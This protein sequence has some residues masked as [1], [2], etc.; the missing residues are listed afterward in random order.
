MSK[1]K[2]ENCPKCQSLY[3]EVHK[4]YWNWDGFWD[5][6]YGEECKFTKPQWKEADIAKRRETY[7][8]LH[9]EFGEHPFKNED[10]SQ[11]LRCLASFIDPEEALKY[12]KENNINFSVEFVKP[13]GQE[14][15]AKT[16]KPKKPKTKPASKEPKKEDKKEEKAKESPIYFPYRKDILDFLSKNKEVTIEE[17]YKFIGDENTK[18]IDENITK[19]VEEKEIIITANKK[20]KLIESKKTSEEPKKDLSKEPEKTE[21]KSGGT[22]RSL[23]ETME[24]VAGNIIKCKKGLETIKDIFTELDKGLQLL[25]ETLQEI[26]EYYTIPENEK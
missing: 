16:E 2:I 8:R 21:K 19:L 4:V 5:K 3:N 22:M 7:L 6:V 13:Q 1:P 11:H 9:N 26:Y 15:Q 10:G 18:V 23:K 12:F 20:V 14:E 24:L 17:I 25:K